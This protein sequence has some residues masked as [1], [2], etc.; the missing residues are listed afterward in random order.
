MVPEGAARRAPASET[1]EC[2]KPK[3]SE[4]ERLTERS[5]PKGTGGRRAKVRAGEGLG[6]QRRFLVCAAYPRH[7]ARIS[8]ADLSAAKMSGSGKE[9]GKGFGERS[10]P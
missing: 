3:R 1:Q 9:L 4:L 8:G 6:K 10:E 5:E 2:P 7:H